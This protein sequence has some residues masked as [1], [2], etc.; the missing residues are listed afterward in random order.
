MLSSTLPWAFLAPALLRR[1]RDAWLAGGMLGTGFFGTVLT[2]F[3]PFFRQ[4]GTLIAAPMFLT[5]SFLL[6]YSTSAQIRLCLRRQ[7][8]RQVG[9]GIKGGHG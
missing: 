4:L 7:A 6:L 1:D 9:H 3:T 8:A 5:V 2:V